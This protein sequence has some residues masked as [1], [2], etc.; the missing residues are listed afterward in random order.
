MNS[1]CS[2]KKWEGSLLEKSFTTRSY[3]NFILLSFFSKII[4][5]EN[6]VRILA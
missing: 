2:F 6:V 3:L 1:F 4:T 5:A